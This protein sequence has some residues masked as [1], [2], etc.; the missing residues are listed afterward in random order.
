[1]NAPPVLGQGIVRKDG[2]LKVTGAASY[3]A[4]NHLPGTAYAVLVGSTIPAGRIRRL[5]AQPALQAP[6]V[7]AVVT[8]ENA[9]RLD[10]PGSMITGGEFAEHFFP[11]QEPEI[12]Y[13]NQ[14]VAVVVADT[15]ERAE[16]AAALVR[17][18]YDA[19]RFDIDMEDHPAQVYQPAHYLVTQK[20]QIARGKLDDGLAAA[21]VS[22]SETYRTPQLNHHPMEPHATVADWTDA[23]LTIYEPTQWVMGLR[24]VVSKSF[25]L[26]PEQVR[27]ISPFVGGGFGSKGFAWPHTLAAAMA[28]RAARRPV[29]LVLTR[30]Q[31]FTNAGHRG[32]TRQELV[33]AAKRDGRLTAIQHATLTTASMNGQHVE[34]CG[35]ATAMLYACP[36]VK[37]T[38]TAARLNTSTPCPTRAPGEAPGLFALESA[39]DELAIKLG[40]DPVEL[41]IRNHAEEDPEKEKPWSSKH[42]LECYQRGAERFGWSRRQAAPGS[43]RENGELVGYGMATATYPANKRD[44]SAAV[45]IYADGRVVVR[46][47]THDLGTGTYT[48]LAQVAADELGVPIEK[49]SCQLGDSTLPA[50]SVSGGS[51]TSA[52]VGPVV[53]EAARSLQ[54]K[55][56]GFASV[57]EAVR[58][59]GQDYLEA[60]AGHGMLSTV[61]AM[62]LPQKF[63]AHSFGAHFVEVRV[64][65][66]TRQIRVSRVVAVI[67]AGRIMN[68]LT[69]RSQIQGGIVWGIGMTLLERTDWD[70]RTGTPVTRNLADYLVPVNA[71]VPDIAV[72]FTDYPD[73]HFNPLG[74]RGIGEIGITGVTAAIANAVH[75]ATGVRVRDLPITLDKILV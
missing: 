45:R 37:I 68:A 3:A 32:P 49:V 72:E 64:N 53:Q 29:K 62:V 54:E 15:L 4:D 16:A 17:V 67:D 34:S 66:A 24:S 23:G 31:L 10:S 6:G 7:I 71:D 35:L 48:S 56:Q 26:K 2:I 25:G 75:H 36:N 61:A 9:P 40:I 43:M 47:A 19:A 55:L 1:M 74:V 57:A 22:V 63:S 18:E 59:S 33:L 13:W 70:P 27:I 50:A 65:P 46:S 60:K 28:S 52:S 44:A 30:A 21:E 39:M 58:A 69:A 12:F 38:H 41:R 51:S 42:L 8:H 5:D 14:Y 73:L 20:L 11:L